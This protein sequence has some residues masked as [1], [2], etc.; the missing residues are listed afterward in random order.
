MRPQ[1]ASASE[2]WVEHATRPSRYR[3]AVLILLPP[4]E[5]KTTPTGGAPLEL[6]SLS[7][8]ELT[9][10]R[11][12]L[13]TALVSLSTRQPKA[14]AAA[15][16]LG[17]TQA[18]EVARNTSLLTAPCAPAAEIYTGVLYDALDAPS[19]KARGRRRLH[20]SVAIASALFGLVRPDDF[21]PAY[22]LSADSTLPR[23]G[24]LATVWRAAL[25]RSVASA[26][27]PVF[28][29]RSG[30]YVALAPIPE[31]AV[32]RAVFGRVLL[33][34]NGRRSVVSHHN[35]ATKGR[36]VRSLVEGA[37]MP[38]SVDSL[39][40]TLHRLGYRVELHESTKQQQPDRL[41]IIVDEV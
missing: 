24:P 16:G 2:T 40:D 38:T 7:F 31:D 34:R 29:L 23:V 26:P 4:S 13:L 15:L 39:P 1:R 12:R 27:G 22:R 36:I 33:E 28:D 5:G 19:L 25:Q 9:P 11:E 35:K 20:A 21:I 8:G 37:S 18:H 32:D 41:D 30:A 3:R 17:P 10:I 6:A 14:V